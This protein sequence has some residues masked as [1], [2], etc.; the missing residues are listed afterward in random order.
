MERSINSKGFEINILKVIRTYKKPKKRSVMA[1]INDDVD[2]IMI[3]CGF[4]RSSNHKDFSAY[5]FMLLNEKDVV[6]TSKG[7][8]ESTAAKGSIIFVFCQTN[9]INAKFHWVQHLQRITRWPTLHYIEYTSTF[10][11]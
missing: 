5:G 9:F 1:T 6:N 3:H 11:S 10:Q 2:K 8:S 4:N 7:L